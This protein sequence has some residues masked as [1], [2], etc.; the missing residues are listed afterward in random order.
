MRK[1]CDRLLHA[2]GADWWRV[3][4][5]EP[6]AIPHAVLV[7]ERA[8][9]AK[10]ISALDEHGI[11]APKEPRLCFLLPVLRDC[12][13][14]PI[15]IHIIRNPLEVAFSLN[16]RNG[17]GVSAGLSLWEAYNCSALNASE[18]LPRVLVFHEDLM[19]RPAGT[20]G[21]VL[22]RLAERGVAELDLS[23]LDRLKQFI[24]PSLYR[25][26]AGEEETFEFLSA[27]QSALWKAFRSGRAFD[28]ENIASNSSA[29]RQQLFDL[30]SA[31]LSVQRRRDRESELRGALATKNR[32]IADL[33]SRTDVLTIERDELQATRSALE[34][35]I[36]T[37]ET[38]IETRE[39]TILTHETTIKAQET[40]IQRHE[41]AI[42][43]R[44]AT[45]RARDAAIRDLLSSTSWKATAPLRAVFRTFRWCRRALRRAPRHLYRLGTGRVSRATT[46][47][48]FASAES[49]ARVEANRS[50]RPIRISN[51][52][53]EIIRES[54]RRHIE[55]A[56]RNTQRRPDKKAL[57]ITV[58]AWD[59][60]HNP[61]G[62]A[63]L[64]ADVLRHEYDVEL[65]GA[66][67]PDFG[68]DIWKPLR[69]C[70]RVKI[71]HVPGTYFPRIFRGPWKRWP[72][73]LRETFFTCP[74]LGF[75]SLE[76]ADSSQS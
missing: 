10:V 2:A 53:S 12:I 74:S 1:I 33:Q 40:T 22:E 9:F 73:T 31:Q 58:I 63:Y 66:I 23:N 21:G 16:A 44:E 39:A 24:Q 70:S 17:F 15:C 71:K 75:P 3:T 7:E 27:S 67:F 72:N 52:V 18:T 26:R 61:L 35:T 38:T 69:D 56:L 51:S 65:I 50:V 8:R 13:T 42:K 19:L 25:R 60:A 41:A 45:I 55:G 68:N 5:F 20:L 6:E 59:L 48:R 54:K 49:S 28:Q 37:H 47:I 76:L 14:S 46:S 36:A 64:L 34:A 30:E 57:K 11:W 62:R 29:T 32:S 4:Q 43:A